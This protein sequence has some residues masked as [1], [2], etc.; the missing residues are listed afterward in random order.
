MPSGGNVYDRRVSDALQLDVIPVPGAW[1][2]PDAAA[3]AELARA[4]QALPD[5]DVVLVDGL[6]AC[7]VPDVV[8]PHAR[9]L[10]LGVLVHLPLADE[11]GVDPSVAAELDRRERET[12][13]AARAVVAT[14][15]AAARRL[16]DHH[17]LARVE[18]VP[19]GV[20]PAPLT[21]GSAS[22]SR[23]LCVASVTPRKGQAVLVE[24]LAQVA[25]LQWSL[26]C[27]GPADGPYAARVRERIELTGLAD[28][29]QLM[30]PQHGEQLHAT[31][32]A[33]DLLVLP[34]H[35]ET[36]GL[37]LTEA[38]AR[39]IPVLASDVGGVPEAVGTS[40]DGSSPG[41][42]VPP[43]DAAALGRELRR[44][45]TEP[46]HRE[47]LRSTA[48]ARRPTLQTWADTAEQLGAVL[49]RLAVQPC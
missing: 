28:R 10:N 7:G 15:R 47:R 24:A 1:P 11:T 40:P 37:V 49:D 35:A 23:L 42:L 25:D 33:A 46:E 38:L 41:V 22:G 30:G 8:V 14:S 13:H 19:P 4:L 6:I 39:G 2:R 3:L 18:A 21:P 43:G 29:I 34:S 12:L 36:Y 9:R 16:A 26:R 5:G 20:D 27:V 32:A 17:G 48:Q 31:Y 44:W 45:L